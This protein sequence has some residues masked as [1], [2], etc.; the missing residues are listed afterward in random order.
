MVTPRS[1]VGTSRLPQASVTSARDLPVF[2]IVDCLDRICRTGVNQVLTPAPSWHLFFLLSLLILI[3]QTEVFIYIICLGFLE[4]YCNTV[5]W[6]RK[7]HK[8]WLS[9]LIADLSGP[10]KSTKAATPWTPRF[11]QI[12]TSPPACMTINNPLCS[13][14]HIQGNS[15]CYMQAK[16]T[17]LYAY[18]MKQRRPSGTKPQVHHYSP[19]LLSKQ[20]GLAS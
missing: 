8:Y 19:L 14:N 10:V 5:Q 6:D 18:V 3:C 17:G 2:L 9:L 11:C 20:L 16:I 1:Q 4:F 7:M 12:C 15:G 13:M